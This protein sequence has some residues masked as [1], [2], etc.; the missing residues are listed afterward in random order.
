MK[1]IASF[2]AGHTK[3]VEGMYTSQIDIDI[4]TYDIRM[5]IP[6]GGVYIDT[7]ASH[8]F[9]HLFATFTRNSEFDY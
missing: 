5:T 8:T 3:L 7:A 2:C 1:K 9:E 6:N 4:T